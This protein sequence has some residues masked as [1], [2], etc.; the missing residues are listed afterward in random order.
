MHGAR[1]KHADANR[2][3]AQPDVRL[4][5]EGVLRGEGAGYGRGDA[6]PDGV[7]DCGEG[8]GER[9]GGVEEERE[10]VA[11]AGAFRGGWGGSG[12]GL[13]GVD[14]GLGAF[15]DG[16]DGRVDELGEGVTASD[17]GA[18]RL[19]E[20][21]IFSL[22]LDDDYAVHGYTNHRRNNQDE[23]DKMK[24]NQNMDLQPSPPASAP[25]RMGPITGAT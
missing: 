11:D 25:P 24:R 19:G 13:G 4:G 17:I 18:A 14:G 15:D 6:V 8:K 21:A 20:E 3:V 22:V 7:D 5:E 9:D 2:Q 1:Q 10:G 16:D 12:G 23:E